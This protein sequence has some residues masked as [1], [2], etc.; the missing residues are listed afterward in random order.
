MHQVIAV[1]L[2]QVDRIVVVEKRITI[3]LQS[4]VALPQTIKDLSALCYVCVSLTQFK[5]L[6]RL[7]YVVQIS[8]QP[9][10]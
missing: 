2:L 6:K 7:F 8:P 9:I 4:L 10:P 1:V 3:V 5:I